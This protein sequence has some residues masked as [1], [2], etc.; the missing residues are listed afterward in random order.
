MTSVLLKERPAFGFC[1]EMIEIC[2][3]WF[4]VWRLVLVGAQVRLIAGRR[5][6]HHV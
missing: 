6:D 4:D 1:A 5:T 3:A 2:V